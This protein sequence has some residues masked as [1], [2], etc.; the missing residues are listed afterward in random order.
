M[1]KFFIYSVSLTLIDQIVKY[2]IVVFGQ[3]QKIVIL[4]AIL[5]IKPVQNTD[6]AAFYLN[7]ELSAI[8]RIGLLLIYLIVIFITYKYLIYLSLKNIFFLD[9]CFILLMAGVLASFID[10][11]WGGT[12]DYISLF[13]R[14]VFDLKDIYILIGIVIIFVNMVKLTMQRNNVSDDFKSKHGILNWIKSS[15][16]IKYKES[17]KKSNN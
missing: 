5:Y 3:A 10:V 8:L 4:P 6:H 1:K 17:W 12:W 14:V 16:L 2:I 9:N 15:L 13:Q 7:M 11:L